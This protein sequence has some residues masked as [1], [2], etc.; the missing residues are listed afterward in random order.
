MKTHEYPNNDITIV[1]T[2]ELCQHA[3]VCVKL[4]PQVYHPKDKPWIK[5]MNASSEELINQIKQCPTGALSY[6]LNK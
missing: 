6:K 5:P 1:W 4:L 2:P 3:G